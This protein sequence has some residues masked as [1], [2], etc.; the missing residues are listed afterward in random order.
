M[1]CIKELSGHS[2][3]EN[4]R[5]EKDHLKVILLKLSIMYCQMKNKGNYLQYS[6]TL[7]KVRKIQNTFAV[8]VAIIW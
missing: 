7:T 3:K 8:M 2:M 6:L 1:H 5:K 4:G